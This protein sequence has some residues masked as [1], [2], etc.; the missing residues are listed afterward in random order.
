MHAVCMHNVLACS[1][2]ITEDRRFEASDRESGMVGQFLG[3]VNA[4]RL[5][6]AGPGG[7]TTTP[8]KLLLY[9]SDVLKLVLYMQCDLI[10]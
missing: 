7:D 1:V 6:R 10:I 9:M 3:D 4:S 5:L 8:G 2:F